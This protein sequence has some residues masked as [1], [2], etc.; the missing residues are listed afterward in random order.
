MDSVIARREFMRRA[1]AGVLTV[2]AGPLK[3]SGNLTDAMG[4]NGL[5]RSFQ[6]VRRRRK[7]G[8][9]ARAICRID[10]ALCFC[11]AVA[12]FEQ[13]R[14]DTG[15]VIAEPGS[16]DISINSAGGT[17]FRM[18]AGVAGAGD[19]E[20]AFEDRLQAVEGHGFGEIGVHAR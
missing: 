8:E 18:H 17:A 5:R 11:S 7:L 20:P 14:V 13:Q 10:E 6:P 16:Q 19:R 12:K 3:L 9:I 4:P 2:G 15:H 1:A